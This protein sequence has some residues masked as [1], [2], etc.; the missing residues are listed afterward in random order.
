MN[1]AV[2]VIDMPKNCSCC[3]FCDFEHGFGDWQCVALDRD[4]IIFQDED[5]EER[6]YKCP[7]K[8]I[9]HRDGKTDG[10]SVCA[11]WFTIGWNKCIDA[12]TGEE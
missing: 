4:W 10:R 1:K 12:I 5:S 2:L 8:P 11:K 9:E 6:Q 7:L 3:M